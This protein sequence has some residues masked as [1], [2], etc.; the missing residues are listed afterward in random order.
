MN[1]PLVS[2]CIPTYNGANYISEA[3]DSILLQTYTNLEVIVSDDASKDNTLQI[4]SKYKEKCS[5]PI[6]VY[7]HKPM[8]IANNWNNCIDKAKGK[9]IK[10]LF[11]D[12]VLEQNCIEKMVHV[13]EN[14]PQI[15]LV[16]CKRDFVIEANYL[17]QDIEYWMKIHSDLQKGLK[18]VSLNNLGVI[19]KSIFKSEEFFK[20]PL[21]KVGEPSTYMFRKTCV[22]K[23]GYFDDT[24]E[25]LLDY[26]FCCRL[27][28]YYNI[29]IMG[30]IMVKFRLHNLQATQSNLNKGINEKSLFE[31]IIYKHLFWCLNNKEKIRLFKKH[32]FLGETLG[33]IT[34]GLKT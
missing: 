6:Y 34:K 20:A 10:F 4:V 8:S 3:L 1:L 28:K 33:K 32:S 5:T 19:N 29:A 21:N 16:A 25:Q 30:E 2:I 22:D 27:L 26:E 31:K 18:L 12:D 7:H 9:Y 14:H 13:L 17:N 15:G 11:Q 24:L 23:I